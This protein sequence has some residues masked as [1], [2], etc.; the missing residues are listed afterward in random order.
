M[1]WNLVV[2]SSAM[3]EDSGLGSSTL[4]QRPTRPS[5]PKPKPK[6]ESQKDQRRTRKDRDQGAPPL[7]AGT[8]AQ[9]LG[10]GPSETYAGISG[11]FPVVWVLQRRGRQRCADCARVLVPLAICS[12][13]AAARSPA[14]LMCC[15]VFVGQRSVNCLTRDQSNAN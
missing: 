4:W 8:R 14:A 11:R 2:V 5:D 7:S 10:V 13:S 12:K 3:E 9:T 6:T 1:R 15:S